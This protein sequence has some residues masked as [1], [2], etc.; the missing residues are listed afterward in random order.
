M[1]EGSRRPSHKSSCSTCRNLYGVTGL[2]CPRVGSGTRCQLFPASFSSATW[3]RDA[4]DLYVWL[5][6]DQSASLSDCVASSLDAGAT[7][8]SPSG[9]TFPPIISLY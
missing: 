8:R 5:V 6:S 9:K 7:G 1:Q 2:S 4:V 3:R